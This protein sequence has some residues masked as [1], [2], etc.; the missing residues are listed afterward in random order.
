MGSMTC[1]SH[2]IFD[3]DTAIEGW[4]SFESICSLGFFFFEAETVEGMACAMVMRQVDHM[5]R[6]L[7]V[8]LSNFLNYNVTG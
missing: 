5:W 4:I 3:F 8:I 2:L 1:L 6:N 7:L